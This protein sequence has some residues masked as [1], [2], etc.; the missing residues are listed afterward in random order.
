MI[1]NELN[2]VCYYCL[3]ATQINYCMTTRYRIDPIPKDFS[4]AFKGADIRGLY[5]VE[6]NEALAYRIAMAFVSKLSLRRVLVARD[7][8][9][10]S[11]T[12][13]TAFVAGVRDAGADVIDIGLAETPALYYASGT[14]D[15]AGVMITASHN[16]KEY[17]GFKL[18]TAGAVPVTNSSGLSAIKKAVQLSSPPPVATRGS[19]QKKSI[20][21]E[22]ARYIKTCVPLSITTSPVRIV[23]DAGN[24]MVSLA[25]ARVAAQFPQLIIEPLFYELDG[26]FPNRDSNPTLA[27]NQRAIVNTLKTRKYDFGVA[28]DGDADRVAFFDEK[29]RY[30]NSAHIGALLATQ[31]LQSK[32]N[33]SF[34]Y[35]VFTSRQYQEAIQNAGGR[36]YKARVGHAYIK[37]K[38]RQ[39]N[40]LFAC[41][42]SAHFYYRDNF[43][44]DS[45]IMTLL[46]LVQT[47]NAN[48]SHGTSFSQMLKPYAQY[49]QTE[50]ILVQVANK[51]AT[52][53]HIAD[54]HAKQSGYTV[55]RFDGVQVACE[56][57][58]FSI[59]KS[60]TEN[61]LKFVVEAPKKATARAIQKELHKLVQSL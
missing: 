32:P 44:V 59:K 20:L 35:T 47:Y 12:L 14:Y 56:N 60:V 50:E 42:H 17:N 9:L 57:Y 31:M 40:A 25:L 2:G 46:H 34:V 7:M 6:I 30:R 45:G 1:L 8:R 49:F 55:T 61:A 24:G 21:S 11:P 18:V 22:Y 13:R 23:V 58:W 48:R 54:L 27:K 41:E 52:L 4:N 26:A 29:G 28:F 5:G 37:E 43:Y 10:S 39:Y 33:E 16:P 51:N 38:M 19:Y 53:A 3:C 15:C 36:A